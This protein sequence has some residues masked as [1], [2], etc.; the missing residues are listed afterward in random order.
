ML[1]E[2]PT[3]QRIYPEQ[4]KASSLKCM[5]CGNNSKEFMGIL[6]LVMH[7][8]M[9]P[10]VL[11]AA[12]SSALK[13]NLINWP[14]VIIIHNSFIGNSDPDEQII[15]TIDTLVTILRDMSFDGGK[16]LNMPR[17]ICPSER[18]GGKVQC[19]LFW[20]A[21]GRETTQYVC[22]KSTWESWVPADQSQ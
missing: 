6:G 17:E 10:K 20:V 21:K 22:W 4:G 8:I 19:N 5:I 3:Q 16:D 12:E 15:V 1:N 2:N 14:A 9:S 18:H 11:P 7:T 13:E